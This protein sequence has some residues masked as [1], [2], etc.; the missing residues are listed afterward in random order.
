[1]SGL[2]AALAGMVWLG[3]QVVWGLMQLVSGWVGAPV[4]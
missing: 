1:L 3:M 4:W 2:I